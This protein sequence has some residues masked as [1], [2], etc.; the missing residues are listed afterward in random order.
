MDSCAAARAATLPA[1]AAA[2]AAASAAWS[3]AAMA[4]LTN[5]SSDGTLTTGAAVPAGYDMGAAAANAVAK[6]PVSEAALRA[7]C[8][9]SAAASPAKVM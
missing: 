7:D 3:A 5:C 1:A 8:A 9:A 2:S 4:A 6:L